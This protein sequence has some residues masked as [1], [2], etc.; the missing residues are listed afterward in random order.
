MEISASKLLNKYGQ[1]QYRYS[2]VF[3]YYGVKSPEALKAAVYLSGISPNEFLRFRNC[4]TKTN[5]GILPRFLFPELQ[6][7]AEQ[8]KEKAILMSGDG[9]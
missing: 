5:P 9:I 7:G 8:R 2:H 1:I 4:G 6:S 3:D